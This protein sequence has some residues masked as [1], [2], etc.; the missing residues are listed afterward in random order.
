M[1]KSQQLPTIPSAQYQEVQGSNLTIQ[2]SH[3]TKLIST[4]LLR[5]VQEALMPGGLPTSL[6]QGELALFVAV[7]YLMALSASVL[8][9]RIVES[10]VIPLLPYGAE[11]WI[12]NTTLLKTARIF[13]S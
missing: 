13:P 12:L 10:C 7:D 2:P 11:S 1:A 6:L 5:T 4:F 3:P 9:K 8:H